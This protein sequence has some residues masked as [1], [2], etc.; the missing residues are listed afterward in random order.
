MTHVGADNSVFLRPVEAVEERA[1]LGGEWYLFNCGETGL[2]HLSV[3]W[4]APTA[5]ADT[6]NNLAVDQDRKSAEFV[7]RRAA[8]AAGLSPFSYRVCRVLRFQKLNEDRYAQFF[9]LCGVFNAPDQIGQPQRSVDFSK[10]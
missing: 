10:L 6:T 1:G 5:N 2:C 9:T 8:Q 4:A 7:G 3:L